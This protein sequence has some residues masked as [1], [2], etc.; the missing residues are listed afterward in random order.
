MR[1]K[2]RTFLLSALLLSI[3]SPAL[4][5]S[6]TALMWATT[7][8]LLIGNALIGVF[9]A[10]VVTRILKYPRGRAIFRSIQELFLVVRGACHSLPPRECHRAASSR[11][12]AAVSL[13]AAYDNPGRDLLVSLC[14]AGMALLVLDH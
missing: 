1:F 13:A 4:A 6:G 14:G 7:F 3:A 9:E 10:V 5:D 2:S 12:R 8:Q 11:R